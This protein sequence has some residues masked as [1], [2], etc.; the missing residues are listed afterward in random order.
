MISP[1]GCASIL[2]KSASKASDAAEALGL[3]AKRLQEL[4]LIE[5]IIPEPLGGAHRDPKTMAETIKRYI[6]G[7]LADLEAMPLAELLE[8]RYKH[9]L[10][11][12]K[13]S[14]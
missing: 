5:Q 1:E 7:N 9:W 11:I 3:T 8:A 10:N 14:T 2:W 6:V 12:G 13:D 4:G